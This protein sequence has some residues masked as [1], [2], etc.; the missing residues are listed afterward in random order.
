MEWMGKEIEI[1]KVHP[2]GVEVRRDQF[3]TILK[4]DVSGKPKGLL[5]AV[6]EGTPELPW[7]FHE[8]IYLPPWHGKKGGARL[9]ARSDADVYK[10]RSEGPGSLPSG[11]KNR[12]R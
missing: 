6:I 9:T 3:Q 2:V 8:K 4:F 7:E 11:D 1:I 12:Y 10:R 5:K